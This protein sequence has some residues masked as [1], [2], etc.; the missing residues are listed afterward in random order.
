MLFA[1]KGTK[2]LRKC[3][4]VKIRTEKKIRVYIRLKTLPKVSQKLTHQVLQ[5]NFENIN[6]ILFLFLC[7]PHSFP[8]QEKRQS[9]WQHVIIMEY[10]MYYW[11][12]VHIAWAKV[13]SAYGKDT[14]AFWVVTY[15]WCSLFYSCREASV[16]ILS[17]LSDVFDLT[18]SREGV[19]YQPIRDSVIIPRGA[20][21]TR[22]L[23]ASLAGALPNNRFE[24]VSSFWT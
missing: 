2:Q 5:L 13:N 9:S 18:N 19:Q 11:S 15:F 17:F 6:V 7:I 16:S 21:I 1:P 23:I 12:C 3:K 24:T 10:V 22:I 20:A 8:S 14:I 4:W